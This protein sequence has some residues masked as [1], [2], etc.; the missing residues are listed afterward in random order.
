MRR[1][2]YILLLGALA[3]GCSQPPPPP[4]AKKLKP[5]EQYSGFLG[6]YSQLKPTSEID[7]DLLTYSNPDQMKNLHRYIAIMVD[8]VEAYLKTD[9]DESL[10]PKTSVEAATVYFRASLIRA[11]SDSYP[12]VSEPSP[13]TLRLR[14]AIVGI[15]AGGAADES[16]T[17]AEGAE[18]PFTSAI[19]VSEVGVEVE[20][21]DS[22]TGERI[23]AAVDKAK[24]GEEALEVAGNLSRVE[25]YH[26]AME[27]FDGW[28]DRIREFLDREHEITGEDAERADKAYVPY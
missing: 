12:I 14:A 13:L 9:A 23:A 2:P 19:N 22:I 17:G 7:S 20:L 16:D 25:K 1:I 27:A 11:V 28:A 15:D 4:I 21:V 26:A 10:I 6:D 24:L 5:G 8:P 3:L 18:Q